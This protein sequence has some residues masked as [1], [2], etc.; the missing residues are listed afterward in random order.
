MKC[1]FRELCLELHENVRLRWFQLPLVHPYLRLHRLCPVR[2]K[3]LRRPDCGLTQAL[4]QRSK[5]KTKKP[6]T[7]VTNSPCFR[8]YDAKCDPRYEF[9]PEFSNN[10]IT[11]ERCAVDDGL[12]NV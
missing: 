12:P 1:T 9:D 4:Q 6:A 7:F 5:G 3:N 10:S 11:G 8:G 2:G